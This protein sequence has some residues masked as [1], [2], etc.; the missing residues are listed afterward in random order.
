M[1]L[2]VIEEGIEELTNM[3]RFVLK[4]KPQQAQASALS[5]RHSLS[6][7]LSLAVPLQQL[8]TRLCSFTVNTIHDHLNSL[9]TL[10]Q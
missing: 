10:L 6:L 9:S 4:T 5:V 3:E 7:S 8:I 1:Q 2:D